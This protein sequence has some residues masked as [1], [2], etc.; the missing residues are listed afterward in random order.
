MKRVLPQAFPHP[1]VTGPSD[2]GRAIR[3]ART[4]AGL[5][6]KDASL[7]LGMAVQT[8]VDIEAGAPGV[9]IGKLMEAAQGLG[10]EIFVIPRG[11]RDVAERLLADLTC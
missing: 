11:C 6:L 1:L 9:S 10:V 5:P 3:A 4:Q 2:I 8:L 7:S